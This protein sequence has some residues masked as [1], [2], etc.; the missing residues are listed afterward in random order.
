MDLTVMVGANLRIRRVH[1]STNLLYMTNVFNCK[2][3]SGNK[4]VRVYIC[5]NVV[6]LIVIGFF[7]A[8]MMGDNQ[9]QKH[10][11]NSNK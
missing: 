9:S 2:W 7:Y 10:I 11:H 3:Q 8:I 4:E 5:K 1:S 6:M